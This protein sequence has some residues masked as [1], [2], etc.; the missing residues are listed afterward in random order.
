MA[1]RASGAKLFFYTLVSDGAKVQVMAD[2][3]RV[4]HSPDLPAGLRTRRLV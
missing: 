2:A 3:R 1:K 4:G